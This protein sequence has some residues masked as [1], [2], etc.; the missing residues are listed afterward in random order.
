MTVSRGHHGTRFITVSRGNHVEVL[1]LDL[2]P[3]THS[4]AESHVEGWHGRICQLDV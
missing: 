2:V 4:N 3:Q 1:P